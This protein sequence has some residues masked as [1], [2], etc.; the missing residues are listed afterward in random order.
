M[1]R[2]WLAVPQKFNSDEFLAM[3][4]TIAASYGDFVAAASPASPSA[5]W[6]TANPASRRPRATNSA[7]VGS[8]STSSARI[9]A[10]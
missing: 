8:S 7:I 9:S 2:S 1:R 3:V 10:S 5:S 4:T 6:S